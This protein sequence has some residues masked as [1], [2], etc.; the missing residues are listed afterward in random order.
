MILDPQRVRELTRRP[1]P[2]PAPPGVVE[3]PV[4]TKARPSRFAAN[5][6]REIIREL[7]A[8]GYSVASLA[9][10]LGISHTAVRRYLSDAPREPK[11]LAEMQCPMCRV[12]GFCEV[13][14]SRGKAGVIVRRRE[15]SCGARFST[16]ETIIV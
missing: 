5:M 3:V 12:I 2:T 14:D 15:C 9:K 4:K 6:R 11:A 13:K 1:T 7:R 16:V 10:Q 8:R